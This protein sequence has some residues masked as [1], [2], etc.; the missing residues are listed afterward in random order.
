[1]AR[2]F[3]PTDANR[4][5]WREWV[6]SRPGPVKSICE[7][8][9]PWEL[10]RLKPTGQ[11]VTFYSCNED[12]TVTVTVSARFNLL[13]EERNVFGVDP[14]DLEPCEWSTNSAMSFCSFSATICRPGQRSGRVPAPP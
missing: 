7:K 9:Q 6:A 2:W 3:E 8:L 5:S 12:G 11:R 4:E 1:M 13:T 14:A 10:Y